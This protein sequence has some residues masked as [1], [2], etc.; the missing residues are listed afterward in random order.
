M[1]YS[2]VPKVPN[3][4]FFRTVI[5]KLV[6]GEIFMDE[7]WDACDQIF[8]KLMNTTLIRGER[9]PDGIYHLASEGI[10]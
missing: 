10:V 7:I 4:W 8:L 2:F 1:Q 6:S 5:E 3:L 9:I